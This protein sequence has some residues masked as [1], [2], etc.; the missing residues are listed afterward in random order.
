MFAA[1]L[2]AFSSFLTRY[3]QETQPY[4]LMVLFGLLATTGFVHGFVYRRRTYRWLFGVCL[5][6]MLYTQGAAI[7]YWFGAAVALVVV[8]RAADDDARRAL[9]RDAGL[10][11]GGAAIVYLPWLPTTIHQ[12][13]HAS[14]P[15]H[16][17]PLMG[18]T[19]PS[20]LLGSERIDV[21]LLV[22][23]L[24]G[25]VPLMAP[26]RRRLPEASTAWTLIAIPA[27][28]LLLARIVGFFIPI[29]AWRYFAPVVAPLLLLGRAGQRPGARGRGGGDGVVR[30]LPRQSVVV[31]TVVQERHEGRRRRD[32]A[33]TCTRVTSSWSASPSRPRW[34]TTTCPP[35]CGT[36]ARSARCRIPAT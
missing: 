15:W 20:Q 29:W 19:I 33:A 22:A 30:R 6:L 14:D 1:V 25:I 32:G 11:F 8:A 31:R 10:C 27:A 5:A 18:A 13:A 2:F 36:R 16:Y 21:T 12:I 7:L 24:V 35:A 17:T 28:A 23:V 4:E 3:A 26:A 9:W 34:P